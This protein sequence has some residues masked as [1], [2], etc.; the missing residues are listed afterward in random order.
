M[1]N[2]S[3]QTNYVLVEPRNVR[4]TLRREK[5]EKRSYYLGVVYDY[6]KGC[7]GEGHLETS[8]VFAS[9]KGYLETVKFLVT[10]GANI[11]ANH[12]KAL[13]FAS[14]DG[15]LDVVKYLIGVGADVHADDDHALKC[16]SNNGRL[17]VSQFLIHIMTKP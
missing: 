4:F 6:K 8:L 16:A 12:D 13:R 11:H 9:T 5:S 14:R 2:D 17:D 1:L 10:R 3:F 7:F 15:H